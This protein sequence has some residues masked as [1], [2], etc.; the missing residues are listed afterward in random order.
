[1]SFFPSL[2]RKALVQEMLSRISQKIVTTFKKPKEFFRYMARYKVISLY[3]YVQIQEPEKLQNQLRGICKRFNLLGRVLI[4]NEGINAALSGTSHAV[5]KFKQE[6]KKDQRL[7][8]LTFREQETPKNA[9]YKLVVRTR[10]EIV[11]FGASVDLAKTGKH[12]APE[13]LKE[14][15][16]NKED[17]VLLD[18]RNDYEHQVGKFRNAQTLPI[19]TFKEF[20]GAVTGLNHLKNKKVVT[21]CT[22]GIRCEKASAFLKQ[23][24]FQNV[25]QL[26]GGIINF[27]NKFP[28]THFEVSCFVFDDRLVDHAGEAMTT[29]VHCEKQTDQYLNCYNLDCDR[30]F[31]CC[32]TCQKRTHCTC[33]E[34]CKTAP[35]QR[36]EA[37][38]KTT[39]VKVIGRV[40]NYYPKKQ[41]AYVQL[42]K[43]GIKKG[44]KLGIQGKTT[45]SFQQEIRELR[46]EDGDT[47]NIAKKSQLIT[48]PVDQKVRKN[49]Q[50]VL[51]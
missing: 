19:R 33:S 46:S 27:N 7:Q 39:K 30:L 48:F 42:Q 25:Y 29:C 49:D 45:P 9:Y 10:K 23:Q 4:G 13:Q 35:R 21:Y 5:E 3:K 16:D 6:L 2:L 26:Q 41:I 12:L 38:E 40:L 34:T 24:G 20:P 36:Q 1:M 32:Q 18:A 37:S 43:G 17:L 50:L 15:L 31:I 22:G 8:G 14:M 51:G 47:I 44:M 11:A 28:N